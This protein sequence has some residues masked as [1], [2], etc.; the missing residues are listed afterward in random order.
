[1]YDAE[2]VKSFYDVYG[3]REWERLEGS[4]AGRL[5]A[6]VHADFVR[7]YVGQGDRVLDA[8]CG[9]RA[10][11]VYGDLGE[12]GGGCDGAGSFR[13][14]VGACEGDGGRGGWVRRRGGF[15]GRGYRGPLDVCGWAF[16][17]ADLLRRRALV[18]V[19]AASCGGG[20]VGASGVM[21]RRR[22]WC[23]WFVPA[24]FCWSA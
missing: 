18:R 4:V 11:P 6:I 1:M 16:R 20:G 8:G 5:K 10:G 23:E 15:C 19:R 14:S 13:G 21:R 22:S 17:C 9:V 3:R 7:R 2:Y 12:A 24:G